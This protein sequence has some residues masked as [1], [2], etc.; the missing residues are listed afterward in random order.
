MSERNIVMK[1]QLKQLVLGMLIN[2]GVGALPAI[3]GDVEPYPLEYFALRAV[4]DN[5]TVS[6]DGK[7]VAMLKILS[8]EGDPVL[9][10]YETGDLDKRPFT[11]DADPAEIYSYY[12]ASDEHIVMTLRQK[13]RD[14][15]KRQEDSV[16]DYKIAI[17]DISEKEFD[18]FDVANPRVE[19]VLPGVPGKIIISE[20]PGM[21]QDLSISEAFRP[22]AYYEMDLD[23][24]T[25][26]LL[27][28]GKV[29]VAQIRFDGNG[30][31]RMAQGYDVGT[32]EY[33][34][35]YRDVGEKRW[36]D[37]YRI[38]NDDFRVTME[39]VL[40]FDDAVPGNLIV[41]AFNGDDKL[42][43]WSF[44]TKTRSFDELLYRRSDVDVYGV[45]RHSNSWQFPDRITAVSYFK[46]NFHF[47][48]F[49]EIE[50]AT[51][52]QLEQLIPNSHYV[53]ITSR[54][55]DGGT[56]AVRNL[57]PRDPGTYYLLHRG[58][59][60]VIGSRQPLLESDRLADV[61]YFQFRAR[62]GRNVAAFATIPNG[63]P[64][65]PTVVMPHGGPH[66][67]EVVLYDEWAQLLANNGYLVIQ[68]QYRMSLG[69]G[70]DH[71]LSAFI[72]GSEA[73][74][75][76][77]DDKDDS[78][79]FFVDE[80]LADPNRMAM[81]GWSYG[82]YASLVAASRTPQLYQCTIAGA[83]V[84]DYVM[85]SNDEFRRTPDGIARIWRDVY[86]Y[87]AVQPVDEAEKVNVPVLLIHGSVDSRVLPKQAKV[88]RDALDK[89]GKYY[90]YVELEG[91]DHFSNTL[92]FNH[93]LELY[94]SLIGFLQN[95]CGQ[96]SAQ[97]SAAN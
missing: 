8:R 55:R 67:R 57:G 94:E 33:Q 44:N 35:L 76:M 38:K 70:L 30:N 3:A 78:A 15:V 31:P 37:I 54:S 39:D 58:E 14:M 49:D 19:N 56:L 36:R 2:V 6:P 9:H 42:G 51:Y 1:L 17:L 10:V 87:G 7:H 81:F 91:A 88:Y 65:F 4:V 72:D 79:L 13:V 90:Q 96:M 12:W 32:K 24:G 60:K 82:G 16:Y 22:R 93:Q 28:R 47:E 80:G 85:A 83:A 29:D 11:V 53:T 92:F 69:Y 66:V 64:P 52:R 77:Q 86:E 20:Q 45:R 68:P 50:G 95:D 25:K 40:G 89:A 71:H 46:D 34:F 43:L 5:V 73:G 74:R 59:F 48:Y 18:D 26:K 84:S 61:E 62:D 23:R 97:T 27:I 63:E 21:E 41:L 75:K